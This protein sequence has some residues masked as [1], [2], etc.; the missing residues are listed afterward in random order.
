MYNSYFFKDP[1]LLGS[2]KP[3]I[4]PTSFVLHGESL[5]RAEQQPVAEVLE[6]HLA[7]V[8]AL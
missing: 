2:L 1:P 3:D 6:V 8:L 4:S 5:Q 7:E